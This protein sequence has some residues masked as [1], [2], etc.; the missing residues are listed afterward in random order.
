MPRKAVYA[1]PER[2]MGLLEPNHKISSTHS[3]D[4]IWEIVI[5][6]TPYHVSLWNEP[7]GRKCLRVQ[8]MGDDT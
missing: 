1:Q 5:N 8:G 4:Y 2:D 7:Q 3:P 6:Y